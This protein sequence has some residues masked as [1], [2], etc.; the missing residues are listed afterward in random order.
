M[1]NRLAKIREQRREHLDAIPEILYPQV[2]VGGVLIV[3]VAHDLK[4]DNGGTSALEEIH[5]NA[6]AER[7][8]QVRRNSRSLTDDVCDATR[9]RQVHRRAWRRIGGTPTAVDEARV[10][11]SR[12]LVGR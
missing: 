12:G 5:R 10:R 7:R 4:S 11:L 9:D 8:Q 6:P 1:L 2:L 3:V